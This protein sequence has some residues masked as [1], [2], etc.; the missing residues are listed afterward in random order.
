MNYPSFLSSNY[1]ATAMDLLADNTISCP[2][3]HSRGYSV[4]FPALLTELLLIV[5]V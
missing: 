3:T 2:L 1:F 4:T 5:R